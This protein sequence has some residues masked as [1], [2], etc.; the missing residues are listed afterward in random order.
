MRF[1]FWI[2]IVSLA[3]TICG[4]SFYYGQEIPFEKQW[5]LFEALRTTA[6]IIFAVVGAWLAIIYPERL[7]FSFG[8]PAGKDKATSN[9][10]V[11]LYPAVYSTIILVCVLLIGIIAPILKQVPIIMEYRTLMRGLS[12]LSLA[13][14]TLWQVAVVVMTAVPADLVKT[15]ADE[16]KV[17]QDV[18]THRSRLV[19]VQKADTSSAR[20]ES[21]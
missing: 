21:D 13:V 4:A 18:L 6:S 14:L 16:E 10:A 7:K 17:E 1:F 5:P 20:P 19:R 12:N 9:V 11:L 15:K 2:I 8:R 3:L